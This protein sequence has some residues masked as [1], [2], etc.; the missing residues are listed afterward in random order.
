[1]TGFERAAMLWGLAIFAVILA[2]MLLRDQIGAL[3]G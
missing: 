2:L 1:M 3:R